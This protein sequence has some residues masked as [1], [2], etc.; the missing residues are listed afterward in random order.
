MRLREEKG[1]Y[2]LDVIFKDTKEE[3]QVTLDSGAGVSVSQRA[4]AKRASSGGYACS[5]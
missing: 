2:V 4:C 5:I 1:T 3:G